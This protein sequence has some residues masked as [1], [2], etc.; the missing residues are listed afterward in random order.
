MNSIMILMP[1]KYYGSW[2]F[3]DPAAGLDREPFVAGI[4]T[5]IDEMVK[6]IPDAENGFKLIFSPTAF[7]GYR[8]RLEW[9]RAESGGNWY[10]S[11]DLKME[12]WLCPAL[13]RYFTTAPK[14]L[15]ARIE[16]RPDLN[17][18]IGNGENE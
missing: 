9:R 5:M 15:Y 6:D 17:A 1:Y 2:V 7:P 18:H 14:E 11:P 10:Y 13:Y 12:G 4:D 16:A 8:L 3:D